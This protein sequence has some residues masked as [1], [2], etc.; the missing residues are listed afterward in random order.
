MDLII[1]LLISY[2]LTI[3]VTAI[4]KMTIASRVKK[5]LKKDFQNNNLINSALKFEMLDDDSIWTSIIPV[6][7]LV[8]MSYLISK[9]KDINQESKNIAKE[10]DE[11]KQQIESYFDEQ[12]LI[13][14]GTL[15]TR[16]TDV[17][18]AKDL[19]KSSKHQEVLWIKPTPEEKLETITVTNGDIYIKDIEVPKLEIKTE[20]GKVVISNHL[21][22]TPPAVRYILNSDDRYKVIK[23]QENTHIEAEKGNCKIK[24]YSTKK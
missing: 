12:L 15:V 4:N 10:L 14:T 13:K 17:I 11:M 3:P 2:L 16:N 6:F 8:E 1:G 9:K 19:P 7:N 18:I 21:L 20:N 5:D 23:D 24:V 22:D